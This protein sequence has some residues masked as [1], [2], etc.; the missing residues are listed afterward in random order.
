[1]GK[2]VGRRIASPLDQ[3]LL[4]KGQYGF[5]YISISKSNSRK[6]TY[7]GEEGA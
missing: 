4:M 7:I 6:T 3:T 2:A 5:K 1:M